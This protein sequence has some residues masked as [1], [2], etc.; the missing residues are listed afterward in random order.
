[1]P[2]ALSALGR[3]LRRGRHSDIGELHEFAREL[4]A[5]SVIRPAV[6]AVLA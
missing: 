6:E 3:H 2:R 4:G 5:P 1:M